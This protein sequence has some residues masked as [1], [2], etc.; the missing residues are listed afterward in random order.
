MEPIQDVQCVRA[1]F[2]DQGQIGLPHIGANELDFLRQILAYHGE[3][4]LEAFHCSFF[5]NPK[6]S[7]AASLDLV[8]QSHVLVMSSYAMN[9]RGDKLWIITEADRSS[10]LA[11]YC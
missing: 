1:I 11:R 6:Q 4:F 7:N 8:D 9:D 2:P 3:E 5:T 10:T